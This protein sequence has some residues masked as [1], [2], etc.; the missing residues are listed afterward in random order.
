MFMKKTILSLFLIVVIA[1]IISGYF[2]YNKENKS[3]SNFYTEIYSN[4]NDVD[5]GVKV[6]INSKEYKMMSEDEKVTMMKQFLKLYESAG[7]ISNLYYDSNNKLY[8][9]TYSN[10]ELDGALGGVSLK[11]FDPMLN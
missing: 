1:I 10:G 11:E 4:Y 5:D 9:F 8:S 7:I 2:I 6:L 3:D